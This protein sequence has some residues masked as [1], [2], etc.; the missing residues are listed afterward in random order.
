[1]ITFRNAGLIDMRAV[2][3]FGV[4]SKENANPIGFFGTGLK[5]AIS[6]ILRNG[7]NI[8]I[9]RGLEKFV[10]EARHEKV[11]NDDFNIIHMN[12]V[13]LGFTTHIG[14][15]WEPWHAFREIYCNML[16]E[17]GE[18]SAAYVEPTEDATTIVV[19]NFPPFDECFVKR[20]SIVLREPPLYSLGNCEVRKGPSNALYYRGILAGELE[21]NAVF[22]Y[23]IT[24]PLTL[25]EDRTVKS[26][27]TAM[28]VLCLDI[29]E[30]KDEEFLTAFLQAEQMSF[31]HYFDLSR[32]EQRPGET[33]FKVAQRCIDDPSRPLNTSA[34]S[35]VAKWLE[36]EWSLKPVMLSQT[37]DYRLER[38]KRLMR[39]MQYN[40]DKYEIVVVK[41]LGPSI[42]GRVMD[43]KIVLSHRAMIMGDNVIFGT[44][45]EEFLH[46]DHQFTDMTRD[47]Q[48]YLIDMIANLATQV[49]EV[50]L[51][52]AAAA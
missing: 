22:T 46:L 17:N 12:G 14:A 43:G 48:N 28:N 41:N 30:C 1:M 40:V 21:R 10:F 26:I 13:P 8:T 33:F 45:L 39:L 15:T 3:T 27:Y 4:S 32:C 44:L 42:L 38:A 20:N 19:S 35:L 16:D 51:K 47:F 6:I 25:T 23:N 24:Y 49:H 29:L 11:R 31:E 36:V 50:E 2:T 52:A 37:E 7:G 34:I 9:Y 18:A 5:Y